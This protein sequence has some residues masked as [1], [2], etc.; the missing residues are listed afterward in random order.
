MERTSYRKVRA[1]RDGGGGDRASAEPAQGRRRLQNAE[2]RTPASR[3]RNT[4]LK[5]A[6]NQAG[7][8]VKNE[9]VRSACYHVRMAPTTVSKKLLP[10]PTAI[11]TTKDVDGASYI[12]RIICGDVLEIMRGMPAGVA[13]IV[14]TSPPYNLKNSTGNGMKD[15]RGGKGANA[16]LQNGYSHHDDCMPHDEYVKWQRDCLTR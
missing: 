16:A 4:S 15:G 7:V 10:R 6:G 9:Y 5:R 2:A 1:S 11:Q 8:N 14:I 12:N 3:G 13:D